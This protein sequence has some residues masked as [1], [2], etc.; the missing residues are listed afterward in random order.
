MITSSWLCC[1][2]SDILVKIFLHQF[3]WYGYSKLL[4]SF[5]QLFF[6]S[7]HRHFWYFG[8]KISGLMEILLI[9]SEVISWYSSQQYFGF[10]KVAMCFDGTLIRVWESDQN[11]IL[12]MQPPP[13][14]LFFSRTKSW[15]IEQIKIHDYF[16]YNIIY[17]WNPDMSKYDSLSFSMKLPYLRFCLGFNQFGKFGSI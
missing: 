6:I 16:F 5:N 2:V 10:P 13:D 17:K 8:W 14:E 4:Q 3:A 12:Q 1:F 15:I 7:M 9:S 11:P